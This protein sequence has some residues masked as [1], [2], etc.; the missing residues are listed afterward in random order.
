MTKAEFKWMQRKAHGLV[1]YALLTGK[2]LRQPCAVCGAS[3]AQ[4]HH[5]DYTKPLWVVWLC[6]THHRAAHRGLTWANLIPPDAKPIPRGP[7]RPHRHRTPE[8]RAQIVQARR[9][10]SERKERSI[11]EF[12]ATL[13]GLIVDAVLDSLS[14]GN[15]VPEGRYAY[16]AR[17]LTGAEWLKSRHAFAE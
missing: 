8:E 15:P 7:F 5:P 2:L 14:T 1:K 11:E 17:P 6:S 12:R 4:A 3:K 10:R 13:R 9:E 16:L